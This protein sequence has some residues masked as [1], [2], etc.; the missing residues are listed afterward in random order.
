MAAQHESLVEGGL[1]MAV[2][3]LDRAVLMREPAIVAG[4]GHAVMAAQLG[5]A[6]GEVILVLEVLERRG[7]A[8]GAML[9]GHA[10]RLPE[11]VLQPVGQGDEALATLDHL[12]MAPAREGEDE[13]VEPV[14][15]SELHCYLPSS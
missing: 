15:G 14:L 3:R 11:G 10:A 1:E 7:E 8:V 5:I 12:G 6:G 2:G 4:R 9:G 13:V